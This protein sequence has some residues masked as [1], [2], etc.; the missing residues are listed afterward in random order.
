LSE[1]LQR[2]IDVPLLAQAFPGWPPLAYFEFAAAGVPIEP[3]E[4]AEKT[5]HALVS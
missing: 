4:L 1:V 3:G 5:G 2:D